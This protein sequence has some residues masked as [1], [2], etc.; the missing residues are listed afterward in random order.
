MDTE[1]KVIASI[2]LVIIGLAFFS[3]IFYQVWRW[4]SR[5]KGEEYCMQIA[6]K[7]DFNRFCFEYMTGR[8]TENR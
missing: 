5:E 7:G 8:N 2:F 6:R 3:F 1:D 4:P